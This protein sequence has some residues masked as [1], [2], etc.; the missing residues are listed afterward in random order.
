MDLSKKS[1]GTSLVLTFLFGPLGL[2]YSSF[3]AAVIMAVVIWVTFALI[4]IPLFCWLFCMFLGDY[5]VQKHNT[6]VD[7]LTRLLAGKAIQNT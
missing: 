4:V 5:Y 3:F 6:N 2:L 1:R 7:K